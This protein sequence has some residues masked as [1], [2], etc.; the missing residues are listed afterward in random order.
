MPPIRKMTEEETKLTLLEAREWLD[1][2]RWSTVWPQVVARAWQTDAYMQKLV[3]AKPAGIR[4][5][6]WKDFGYKLNTYLDLNFELDVNPPGSSLRMNVEIKRS[7]IKK[8]RSGGQQ[9]AKNAQLTMYIPKPPKKVTDQA[10]EITRYA[11]EGRTYPFT[12]L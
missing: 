1:M 11:E 9:Q 5:I 3:K 8:T 6:L 4:S 2:I 12:C 10:V 7:Q